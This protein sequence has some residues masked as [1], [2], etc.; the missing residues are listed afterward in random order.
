MKKFVMA[1]ILAVVL[2]SCVVVPQHGPRGRVARGPRAAVPAGVVYV[3]P[4]S[5]IPGR[6]YVWKYHPRHG[7]GW[8]HPRRGWYLGW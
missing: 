3:V 5:K 2:T 8:R 6:G 7:W 1:N 4:N